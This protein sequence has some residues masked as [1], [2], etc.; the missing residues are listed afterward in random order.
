VETPPSMFSLFYFFSPPSVFFRNHQTFRIIYISRKLGNKKIYNKTFGHLRILSIIPVS[1]SNP[2]YISL[3]ARFRPLSIISLF[4]KKI[5]RFVLK[6][7]KKQNFKKTP[8]GFGCVCVWVI[9]KEKKVFLIKNLYL[10]PHTQ[11]NP[12]TH[13]F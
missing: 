9:R 5:S 7:R 1:I 10:P 12:Y 11:T 2:P 4:F 13:R 6:S 3:R 8:V